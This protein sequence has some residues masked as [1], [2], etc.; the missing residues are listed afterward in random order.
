MSLLKGASV[1][2]VSNI[3]NAVIPFL[4]LPILTRYLSPAE[5]GQIAMFQTLLAGIGTFIGLN[6]IGAANRKFYDGDIDEIFLRQF[7]GSCIQILIVSGFIAFI[8][9]LLF[10]NQLSEFLAI[11]T[12]WILAAVVISVFGFITSMRLGQ[13]QIRSQAKWFGILQVSSSLINMLLSLVFVIVLTQGAQG[14]IDAQVITGILAAII[15]LIW[16][17]K[18]KL[19]QVKVWKPQYIKE[20]LLFGIPLIP[21]HVGFFLISA[22]D[23]FVINQKLGLSEAGIYMVAIQLS[24]AMAIV[25]DAINKAYVPWL[26]EK[27]KLDDNEDKKIIVKYTYIYFVIALLVGGIAFIIGP[28]FITLIAGEKYKEAGGFIGFLCLGQAFGGMYLMVT[29]YIF[30]S[31]KTGNLA[32]VT[33]VTGCVNLFLLFIL[34]GYLGIIGAAIAFCISKF[35]QFILTWILANYSVKMPWNLY[36]K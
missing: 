2:L 14:R 25:F 10:K 36:I 19:L 35:I 18:D 34:I 22:V 7:N 16:L 6:A 11:P 23:R 4:L 27:L 9:I 21:H 13:W 31:K 5:Y 30:Y 29:N 15:A 26:F 20:A 12:S 8:G 32:I 3:L 24:S 33:I 17:Y 28:F 1:Y